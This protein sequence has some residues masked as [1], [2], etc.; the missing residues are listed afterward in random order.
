MPPKGHNSPH[1]S[2]HVYSGQ[3]A[4]W[5]EIP[6]GTDVSL[7]PGHILLDRDPAHPKKGHSSRSTFCPMSIVAR[8]LDGSRC[9]I[10]LDG[11]PAPRPRKGPLHFSAHVCNV[12]YWQTA[13]WIKMPLGIEVTLCL[14]GTQLPSPKKRHSPQLSVH[15]CCGQ[16]AGWIRIPL[17]AEVGHGPGNVALDGDPAPLTERGTAAPQFSAHVYCGQMIAHQV[18]SSCKFSGADHVS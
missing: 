4:R 2:A 13:R 8:Q 15:V 16:T 9:H 17:R 10:V 3:T 11:D 7:S 6:L 1:F 12:C 18:L 5:I 14:T